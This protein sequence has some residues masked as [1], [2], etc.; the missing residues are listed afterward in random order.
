MSHENTLQCEYIAHEH[1]PRFSWSVSAA[2]VIVSTAKSHLCSS[3]PDAAY[4][5][6]ACV[7]RAWNCR[8]D[9]AEWTRLNVGHAF[10]HV[11]TLLQDDLH[12]YRKKLE[13]TAMALDRHPWHEIDHE[14]STADNEQLDS[15]STNVERAYR[16]HNGDD[17]DAS[18]FVSAATTAC[19]SNGINHNTKIRQN[20]LYYQRLGALL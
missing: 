3:D 1:C 18:T 17:Y 4:V 8:G 14:R 15:V 12:N 11:H 7:L 20:P 13:H 5:A 2:Y 19:L 9:V 16:L 6:V 10:A